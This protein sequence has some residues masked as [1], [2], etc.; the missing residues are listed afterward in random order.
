MKLSALLAAAA[1]SAGL[2][3]GSASA[4]VTGKVVLDGEVPEPKQ[5]NMSANPQCAAA[6]PNPVLEETIVVGDKKEL[7]NVVVSLKA[8]EGK[9]L[10]G[11]APKD[12]VVLDQKG[13]QYVPHVV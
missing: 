6:H 9:E 12:P 8:P 5:I 2:F 1:V 3:A 10:K 11:E 13:C 4:Q 7:A